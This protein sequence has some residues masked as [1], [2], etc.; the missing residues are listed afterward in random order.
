[1]INLDFLNTLRAQA[2]LK[3]ERGEL[4]NTVNP[5]SVEGARL[6]K[7]ARCA[8]CDEF[9]R[10]GEFQYAVIAE[11]KLLDRQRFGGMHFTCHAVWAMEV[12]YA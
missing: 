7:P 12:L 5:L 6:I 10:E 9:I 11:S 8:M 1:M 2:R 4:P 3:I